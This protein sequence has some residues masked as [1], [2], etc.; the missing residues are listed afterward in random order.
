[1]SITNEYRGRSI[2]G[3]PTTSEIIARCRQNG[4]CNKGMVYSHNGSPIA[5]IKYGTRDGVPEGEMPTQLHVYNAFRNMKASG[6]KVPEIYHAFEL[7]DKG[8]EPVTYIVMEY[9]HG[10]S[11][12]AAMKN[13]SQQEKSHI[14]DQVAKAVEQL[15]KVRPPDGLCLG[16][17]QRGHIH[18]PLFT[19]DGACAKYKS[20]D[21]L[22]RHFNKVYALPLNIPYVLTPGFVTALTPLTQ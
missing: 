8:K 3:L 10:Q 22:Q 1:M 7:E 9:V 6:F 21:H 12:E 5:Y 14:L 19:E 15:L 2:P 17:V 4:V 11:V 16:P 18:H 13:C 20:V